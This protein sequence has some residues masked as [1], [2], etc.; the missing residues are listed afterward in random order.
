[1]FWQIGEVVFESGS[2]NDYVA[3]KLVAISVNKVGILEPHALWQN[4]EIFVI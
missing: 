3:L 1:V 4:P 2:R